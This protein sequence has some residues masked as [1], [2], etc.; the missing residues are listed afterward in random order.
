VFPQVRPN[1]LLEYPEVKLNVTSM[2]FAMATV[3]Y[4]QS[5]KP[6]FALEQ[7]SGLTNGQHIAGYLGYLA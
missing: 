1:G 5:F 6:M 4:Y 7:S 2:L 3:H